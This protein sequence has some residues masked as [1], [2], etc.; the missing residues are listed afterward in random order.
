[1]ELHF[2]QFLTSLRYMAYGMG[3]IFLVVLVIFL[4]IVLLNHL[5]NGKKDDQDQE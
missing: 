3:G 5:P 1:M 2:D 4:A